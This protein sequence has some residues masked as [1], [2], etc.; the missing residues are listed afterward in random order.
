MTKSLAEA[1]RKQ[2]GDW[3]ARGAGSGEHPFGLRGGPS[4][5]LKHHNTP[6]PHILPRDSEG[7]TTVYACIRLSIYPC[8]MAVYK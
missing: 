2:A 1:D 6:K 8:R 3:Q 7:G 5:G 4:N